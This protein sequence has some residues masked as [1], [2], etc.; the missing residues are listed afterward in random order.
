MKRIVLLNGCYERMETPPLAAAKAFVKGFNEKNHYEVMTINLYDKNIEYCTG[1]KECL[2]NKHKCCICD[3][4]KHILDKIDGASYIIWV[5]PIYALSLP[6]KIKALLERILAFNIEEEEESREKASRRH[7]LFTTC[8]LY[9][10]DNKFEE[11]NKYLEVFFGKNSLRLICPPEE[12]ESLNDYTENNS[13]LVKNFEEAGREY[14]ASGKITLE[15]KR[16]LYGAFIPEDVL[17]NLLDTIKKEESNSPYFVN[18]I[19]IKGHKGK[20]TNILL[21]FLPWI[22]ICLFMPLGSEVAGIIALGFCSLIPIL[23][24]KYTPTIYDR[25]S[26]SAAIIIGLF[27]LFSERG[28]Y[29]ATIGYFLVGALFIGSLLTS[30]PVSAYYFSKYNFYKERFTKDIFIRT[31]RIISALMGGILILVA[32][33]YKSLMMS[34][35]CNYIGIIV[36]I[37]FE[38]IYIL[39]MHIPKRVYK[40]RDS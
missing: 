7:I 6:P 5:A 20:D 18:D 32:L 17:S 30:M 19:I 15:S 16:K 8:G 35:F 26:T 9:A 31:N 2:S 14:K 28:I 24:F 36:I 10:H 40:Y 27:L 34:G 29:V 37:T 11:L 1:C 22:A 38:L 3:D 39:A 21:L 23:S 33:V 25:I 12:D 13:V 4:F